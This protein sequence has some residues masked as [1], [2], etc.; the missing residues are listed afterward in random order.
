LV[1]ALLNYAQV[2]Q[3]TGEFDSVSM[4]AIVESALDNLRILILDNAVCVSHGPLPVV[5][6]D[7]VLLIQLLQ[8]LVANAIKYRRQ[9][10]PPSIQIEAA[11][12][13]GM[14]RFAVSDNGEGI[15]ARY[16]DQIFLPLKRLHGSE[17]PG[18]GMGL[19]VCRKIIERHGGHISVESQPGRGSTF[20]FTLPSASP[21]S[22]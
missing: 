4:E 5:T 13:A 9:G 11:L 8:N 3:E 7:R 15:A 20:F 16:Q 18:T 6:G 19:A 10:V 2:G 17:V 21:G 14:W 1:S 12:E 22:K